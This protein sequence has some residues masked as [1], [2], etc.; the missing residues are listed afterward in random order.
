MEMLVVRNLLRDIPL[1][2]DW[3][4][5]LEN[6]LFLEILM[7]KQNILKHLNKSTA[8]RRGANFYGQII[9]LCDVLA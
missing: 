4:C 2:K 9:Q 3:F 1:K 6:L 7:N 8:L 5:F